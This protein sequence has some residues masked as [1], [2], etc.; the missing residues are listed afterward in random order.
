[1]SSKVFAAQLACF[2]LGS[3]CFSPALKAAGN[4]E[5]KITDQDGKVRIEIDRKLF[6]EYHYQNIPRPYFYPI[7]D[8]NELPM[9]RN[10]PMKDTENEEHD[11]KHH[12]SLWFTHG[13]VNGVD[14]WSEAEKV[15]KIVHD[16][17][18]EISSGKRSNII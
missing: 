14:F 7:I 13:E 8:P 5:V 6:T 17:F 12:R 2:L 16:K 1:M 4:A 11:H 9:T 18:T 10:W 3:T 15:G